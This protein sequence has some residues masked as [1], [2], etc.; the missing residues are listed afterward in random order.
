[1]PV[2]LQSIKEITINNFYTLKIDISKER[3]IIIPD[4]KPIIQNKVKA[5]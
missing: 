4:N 2:L 5:I 1:M 3:T